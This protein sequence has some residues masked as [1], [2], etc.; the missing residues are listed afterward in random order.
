MADQ[1]KNI[2]LFNVPAGATISLPHDLH[3][4]DLALIPDRIEPDALGLLLSADDVNVTAMNPT[5]APITANVLAE[6]WHSI[7]R[8]FGGVQNR[9][10]NPQPFIPAEGG[11]AGSNNPMAPPDQWS[12]PITPGQRA[13]LVSLISGNVEIKMIR[14]GSI[15][16]L[17]TQLLARPEL[18]AKKPGKLGVPAGVVTAGTLTIIVTKNGVAQTLNVVHTSVLNASGGQAT[19][20][21]GIDTYNAG[22]TI[23]MLYTATSDLL[24]NDIVA[25]P[26]WIEVFETL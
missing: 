5:L 6:S 23:G 11:G 10:L 21:P 9:H 15:V 19:Q 24:P 18:K 14:P 17:G 1:L 8:A 16:G 20:A 13:E 25:V 22:D 3:Q 4:G 26:C 12:S 2:L 7:E